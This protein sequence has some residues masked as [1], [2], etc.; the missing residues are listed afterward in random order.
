MVQVI[1]DN[2][3]V[4]SLRKCSGKIRELVDI[5]VADAGPS[6]REAA[7]ESL[8]ILSKKMPDV[9][10][11]LIFIFVRVDSFIISIF[12]FSKHSQ[13]LD[14]PVVV[15]VSV[16]KSTLSTYYL[17]C[18]FKYCLDFYDNRAATDMSSRMLSKRI[19]MTESSRAPV[20]PKFSVSHDITHAPITMRSRTPNA[21]SS[22]AKANSQR[23]RFYSFCSY[24][25]DIFTAGSRH[26]S[27]PGRNN[28]IPQSA[29]KIRML[30]FSF[31]L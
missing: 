28:F 19:G 22:S 18:L 29:S 7:R 30:L 1:V 27:P 4:D 15:E 3:P 6:A 13:R 17:L 5:G 12:S 20:R 14:L 25:I 23:R 8:N 24:E 21:T 26:N 16:F 10:T 9:I 2:W 31:N 11:F